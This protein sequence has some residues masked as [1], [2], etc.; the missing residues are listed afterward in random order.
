MQHTESEELHGETA[1]TFHDCTAQIS[2]PNLKDPRQLPHCSSIPAEHL[3]QVCLELEYIKKTTPPFTQSWWCE[4]R[5]SEHALMSYQEEA[6]PCCGLCR[7]HWCVPEFCWNLTHSSHPAEKR[8]YIKNMNNKSKSLPSK[9]ATERSAHFQW[10]RT[11]RIKK[12][13]CL[14]KENQ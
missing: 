7:L 3:V 5:S 4:I 11:N 10:N 6:S 13:K 8:G 2:S 9:S 14:T 1:G 12:R